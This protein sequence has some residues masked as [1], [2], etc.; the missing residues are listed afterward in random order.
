MFPDNEI[1][2]CLFA[3]RALI[4]LGNF[5]GK[6]EKCQSVYDQML[7]EC[8]RK[9]EKPPFCIAWCQEIGGN[10]GMPENRHFEFLTVCAIIDY[11]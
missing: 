3:R 4:I 1:L 9:G 5:P 7:F 8:K 11:K 2:E 10:C 6:P